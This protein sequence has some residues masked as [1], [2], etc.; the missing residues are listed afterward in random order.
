MWAIAQVVIKNGALKG[1]WLDAVVTAV[2]PGGTHVDISTQQL[3]GDLAKFSN[4]QVPKIPVSDL[5]HASKSS[6]KKSA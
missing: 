6:Y 2:R 5:R 1:R 3:R 4:K